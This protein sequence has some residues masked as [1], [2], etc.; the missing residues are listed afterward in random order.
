[1]AA[2]HVLRYLC[3]TVDYGLEYQRGD[4]FHLVGYTDSYWARCVSDMKSTS[5][6]CFRLGSVVVSWFSRKKKSV[7]LSSV[8]AEYMETNQ[9]SCEALWLCKLLVGLFGVQLRPTVIYC[10]NESCIKLSK[11]PVFH[12]RSKNIEIRYHFIHEYVQRGAVELQYIS[13][14]KQVAD[15]LT[16]ALGRGKFVFFRDN[17]GVLSNTF[18]GKRKC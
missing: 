7:A 13:T 11:N 18:L 2:K 17:L 9:A 3:G 12:D 14:K 4:G 10:D 1:V 6:C 15:I 5:G 16:K 8:E